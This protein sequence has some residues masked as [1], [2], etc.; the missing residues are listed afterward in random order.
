[1]TSETGSGK[2]LAYLLPILN[3]LYNYKDRVGAP[4]KSARFKMN[5]SNEDQMF[6]NASELTYLAQKNSQSKR[7]SFGRGSTDEMKG[8][9][10][11]SYSK[12]LL[13]QIY[14]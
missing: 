2:T 6:L 4:T 1:M 13:N 10:I 11:L 9:I 14:V 7:L 8:A 5:K 12:E 3:Q